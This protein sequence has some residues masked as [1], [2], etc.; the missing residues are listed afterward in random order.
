MAHLKIPSWENSASSH[1]AFS[2]DSEQI[3]SGF[4]GINGENG[5]LGEDMNEKWS[6]SP[7]WLFSSH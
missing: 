1:K 6:Q 7:E 2:I 5:T 3:S 4:D